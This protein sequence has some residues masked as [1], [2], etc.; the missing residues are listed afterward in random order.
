MTPRR[1]RASL[2]SIARGREAR[3]GQGLVE[4]TLL[5]PLFLVL[6]LGM[7][8]LGFAF[9]HQLTLQ[10][11]TR[12]GARIGADLVNGG[13]KLGCG[14]GQSPNANTVDPIIIEAVDRVLT[15]TGSPIPLAQVSQIRIFHADSAGKDTL[16]QGDN[17]TYT[18][19]LFT[20]YDGTKVNFQPGATNWD[21]CSRS[22]QDGNTYTNAVDSIGISISYAYELT[23]PLAGA[24]KLIGGSQASTI[25]MTDATVM[26]FNP[27]S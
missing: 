10:Y 27:T 9:N 15:S 25:N 2:L 23:T 26:Q 3:R 16:N 21:A 7:L 5:V 14:S 19:S 4:F 13:G 1:P 20:L 11:A 22:N 18:A 17:W 6:L 24:M 8:E 12:E